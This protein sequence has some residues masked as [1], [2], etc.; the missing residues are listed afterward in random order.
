[1]MSYGSSLFAQTISSSSEA[2]STFESSASFDS[3]DGVIPGIPMPV[4]AGQIYADYVMSGFPNTYQ[5]SGN[6]VTVNYFESQIRCDHVDLAGKVIAGCYNGT[7]GSGS[8]NHATSGAGKIAASGVVPE[9]RGIAPGV[10][11]RAGSC[12]IA[13]ADT[14]AVCSVSAAIFGGGTGIWRTTSSCPADAVIDP[15]ITIVVNGR[16]AL[17]GSYTDDLDLYLKDNPKYSMVLA[18]GNG[19]GNNKD[20]ELSTYP[21]RAELQAGERPSI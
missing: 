21:T 11:I 9:S 7:T 19:S 14:D 4:L 20:P 8:C 17:N 10:K 5:L 6:G 15:N 16:E 3:S 1:M 2:L 18:A 13:D 12:W